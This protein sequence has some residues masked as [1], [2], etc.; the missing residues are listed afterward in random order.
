MSISLS[1]YYMGRDVK[2]AQELT[3]AHRMNAEGT[4]ARANDLLTRFGQDRHVVSGWRPAI[5]NAATKGAAPNSKHML[6]QAVDLEDVNRE[7]V[8]WCL[9]NPDILASI[10]LWAEDPRDTPTW[11][12]VQTVPPGSGMRF[13]RA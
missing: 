11:L 13:F 1:D 7:L 12:H 5:I 4:V 10:G 3:D 6:C 8:N 2:F 9:N